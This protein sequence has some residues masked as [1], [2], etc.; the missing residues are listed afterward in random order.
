MLFSWRHLWD[1]AV[2]FTGLSQ[3]KRVRRAASKRSRRAEFRLTLTLESLEER[4]VPTILFQPGI[5]ETAYNLGGPVINNVHPDLV[6]WGRGWN[7][8]SGPEMRANII[9]AVESMVAS[10][11][12]SRLSEYRSSIGAGSQVAWVTD[13]DSSPGASFSPAEPGALLDL[14]FLD[15]HIANP[16]YQADTNRLYIV[17]PQPGSVLNHDLGPMGGYHAGALYFPPLFFFPTPYV[18]ATVSNDGILDHV[19]TYLSSML[20]GSISDPT[21]LAVQVSPGSAFHNEITDNAAQNYTYRFD[22]VNLVQSWFSQADDAFIVPTNQVQNFYVTDG[23]LTVFGDQLANKDDSISIDTSSSGGVQVTLNGETAQFEPG[24]IRSVRIN[25]GDGNNTVNISST[26]TGIPITV[27]LG[28]GT[29]TV[30]VG[31]GF[32]RLIQQG[33]VTINGQ[34]GH[35]TLNVN[36]QGTQTSETYTIWRNLVGRTSG[37]LALI[38]YYHIQNLNVNAGAATETINVQSTS[39]DT[40]TAINLGN[41]TDTVNVGD[42]FDTLNQQGVM[43]INGQNGTA[44]LNVT[45][46]AT[47]DS[48]T[49]TITNNMVSRTSVGLNPI[50]FPHGLAPIY[51]YHIQYVNVYA[52]A[53][54]ETINVQ[55]TSAGTAT[56]INLGNGTDT[57]NVGDGF[58]RLV[59]LGAVTINGRN[60]TATL[61][62]NDQGSQTWETYT[63]TNNMVSRTS[64]GLAPIYYSHIQNVNVS[65]AVGRE[66]INVQS[67]S[68]PTGTTIWAGGGTDVV[69]VGNTLDGIAGPLWVNGRGVTRLVVLDGKT[70]FPWDY[71]GIYNLTDSMVQRFGTGAIHYQSLASVSL[72]TGRNASYF[73]LTVYVGGTAHGTATSVTTG[74]VPPS[75]ISVGDDR[76]TLDHIQGPLSIN[77]AGP[78]QLSVTDTGRSVDTSYSVTRDTIQRDGSAAISYHNLLVPLILAGG[79]GH[80]SYFVTSTSAVTPI[81]LSPSS[82]RNDFYLNNAAGTVDDFLLPLT[83]NGKGT[84]NITL[85]DKGSRTSHNYTLNSTG[86]SRDG[87][88]V[89][90]FSKATLSVLAGS[91]N[92][93]F[94]VAAAPSAFSVSLQGGAGSNTLVGPDDPGLHT[95]HVTGL[96]AGTLSAPGAAAVTFAGVQNLKG[97]KGDDLFAFAN[98][99]SVSGAVNGGGG[100]NSLDYSAYTSRVLV[101]LKI[102]S[103]TGVGG[104]IANI[105]IVAGGAGSNLLVGNGRSVLRGGRGRNVLIAGATASTLVGGGADSILIAGTTLYDKDLV[106]LQAILDYWAGSDTYNTR[107]ANLTAGKGVPQ[108]N[109]KTV[110]S[111]GGGNMLL[112][113][114]GLDLFYGSLAADTVLNR[115]SAKETF[116]VL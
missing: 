22:G 42:G 53:A 19:T 100:T 110:T 27:N 98:G 68:A 108:L 65:A 33:L 1:R 72:T 52:G 28:N 89:L 64:G 36:D 66:T 97:G 26:P 78:C 25:T 10:P 59:E 51:Y 103:A 23:A 37:G 106:S 112:G 85:T 8:G 49:Y 75:V 24:A 35:A 83:I 95:W 94:T 40:T 50:F 41:G 17:I 82:Q 44:Y 21:L 55:S 67:T 43:T 47:R 16:F 39:A 116:I 93:T 73:P 30:N 2:C 9:N 88:A 12:V 91:G 62:V 5:A 74:G 111:N 114:P 109:A 20:V 15:T 57:V 76:K 96:N 60:G 13:T 63:I 90:T 4:T 84:S 61:N 6:F 105:Q 70:F 46:Q 58:N 92:N 56:A 101:D 71:P 115:D 54:T 14:G 102:G 7:T 87:H 18:F 32:N 34:N 86:L 79:S 80:D 11:Y 99:A 38:Y 107:V 3:F 81:V 104:G 29:D 31:D 69:T 45:D 48:E 77:G 113:G